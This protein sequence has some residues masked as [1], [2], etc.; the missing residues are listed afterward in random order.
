[1]KTYKAGTGAAG[2]FFIPSH[3]KYGSWIAQCRVLDKRRTR[4]FIVRSPDRR[5]HV[6]ARNEAIRARQQMEADCV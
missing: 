1:M 2:V 4:S 6:F 5:H 3:S